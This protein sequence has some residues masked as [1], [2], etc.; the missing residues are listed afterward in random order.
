VRIGCATPRVG[1]D[2]PAAKP[3]A[4][5]PAPDV[6][7]ALRMPGEVQVVR[8]GTI[9]EAGP[10]IVGLDGETVVTTSI[11]GTRTE[12][13]WEDLATGS[14]TSWRSTP[15]PSPSTAASN[16]PSRSTRSPRSTTARCSSPP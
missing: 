15:T 8:R 3:P 13:V 7:A 10:G 12:V 2:A 4:P 9:G 11:A 5:A 1:S 16:R 14:V 6:T